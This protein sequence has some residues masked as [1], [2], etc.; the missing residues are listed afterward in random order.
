VT[1][2][3]TPKPKTPFERL[4]AFTKA[5]IAVPKKEIEKKQRVYNRAKAKRAKT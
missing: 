2:P 5:L 3:R 4:E 1:E